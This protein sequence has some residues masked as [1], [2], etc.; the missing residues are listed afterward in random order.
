MNVVEVGQWT[1]G[2]QLLYLMLL[3]CVSC[4]V[5]QSSLDVRI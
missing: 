2:W 3:I 5:S 1:W 4:I